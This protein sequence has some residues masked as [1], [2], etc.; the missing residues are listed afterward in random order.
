MTLFITSSVTADDISVAENW[1]AVWNSHDVDRV[2]SVFTPDVLYEDVAF[3]VVNHGAAELR[4]F[5]NGVF[6]AVPDFRLD[7]VNASLKGGHGTIEW[8]LTG[9]DVGLYRTGRR[10][11][12]RGVSVIDVHGQ[13][14]FRNSDY[15]DLATV[16]RQLG[17][18]PPGL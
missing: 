7:L 1:I 8:V 12:V 13:S 14:I 9:T 10:F 18:L 2:L 6:A 16:Q 4:A 11:S 5:A 3:G 17:L 15:Y